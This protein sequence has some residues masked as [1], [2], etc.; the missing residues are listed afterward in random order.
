MQFAPDGQYGEVSE[1]NGRKRTIRRKGCWASPP[2]KPHEIKNNH[3]NLFNNK[4]DVSAEEK[5]HEQQ[6]NS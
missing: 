2:R 6:T 3:P 5:L 4:A 1:I